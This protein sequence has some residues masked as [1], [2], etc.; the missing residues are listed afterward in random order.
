MLRVWKLSQQWLIY[1]PHR[2]FTKTVAVD[3]ISYLKSWAKI[4]RMS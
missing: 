3:G 1:F 2:I 4:H